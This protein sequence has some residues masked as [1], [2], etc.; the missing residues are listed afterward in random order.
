MCSGQRWMAS[1]S[2]EAGQDCNQGHWEAVAIK[3]VDA[4]SH[5]EQEAQALLT[6]QHYLQRKEQE[7][8]QAGCKPHRPHLLS[9][10]DRID[11]PDPKDPYVHLITRW[12]TSGH[13]C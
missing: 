9:L 3:V 4:G 13:L 11:V 12:L 2:E 10:L 6:V 7:A 8:L 5:A 1:Y